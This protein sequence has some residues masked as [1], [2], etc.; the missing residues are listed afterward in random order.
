MRGL[1][2]KLTY[3]NVMA[4]SRSEYENEFG[5][6]SGTV[7]AYSAANNEIYEMFCTAAPH[8]CSGAINATVF[9]P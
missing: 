7:Y 8:E 3:A 4:T 1:R 6:G 2:G 9:F 5:E